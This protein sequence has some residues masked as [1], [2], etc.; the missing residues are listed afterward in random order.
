M[1]FSTCLLV[2]KLK[3]IYLCSCVFRKVFLNITVTLP[4]KA[5]RIPVMAQRSCSFSGSPQVISAPNYENYL[6]GSPYLIYQNIL[7]CSHFD[8]HFT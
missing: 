2:D 1:V 4:I 8:T 6:D 7:F 5:H 3:V